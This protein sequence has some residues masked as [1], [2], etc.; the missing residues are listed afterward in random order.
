MN[1]EIYTQNDCPPCTFI[2]QYFDNKHITYTEKNIKNM[3]YKIEMIELDAMSTP[4]IKINNKVFYTP[5]I[6]AIEAYMGQQND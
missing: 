5:D 6:K 4:L 2:K 1:I 3:N